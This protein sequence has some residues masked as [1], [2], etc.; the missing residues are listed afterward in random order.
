MFGYVRPQLRAGQIDVGGVHQEPIGA[1][2]LT[3]ASIL[4]YCDSA[5]P[6]LG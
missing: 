5:N 6:L 3:A 4:H 2:K 1:S